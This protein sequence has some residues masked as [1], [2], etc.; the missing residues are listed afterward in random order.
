MIFDD[1]DVRDDWNSSA[2]WRREYQA[3]GGRS[4]PPP[5]ELLIYQHPGNLSPAELAKN[6][7]FQQSR[8]R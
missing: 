7:L 6:E 2:S 4:D 8:S 5:H 3:V 1:H